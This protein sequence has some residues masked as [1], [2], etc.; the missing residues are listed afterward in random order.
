MAKFYDSISEDFA[1]WINQQQ[2]FFVASAPLSAE[3]HVNLSPKGR[4]C[5]RVLSPNRVA[6][7]DMTGSGNET[8]AHLKENGRMTFMFCSFEAAPRVMRLF[9]K[10]RVVL[11]SDAEWDSLAAN[12]TLL[13]G[14]RQIIVADV[15]TVQSSCGFAVPFMDYVGEREALERWAENKGEDG[16]AAYHAEKNF[17]SLD[18]LPSHLCGE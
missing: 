5:L 12:F 17:I 10:G 18:G 14:T 3:G 8:S 9:A 1:T 16:L 11:P 6:Y 15:H 13:A 7:V 2:L 4:D